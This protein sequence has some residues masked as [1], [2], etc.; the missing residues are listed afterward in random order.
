MSKP[1]AK[2]GKIAEYAAIASA[3]VVIGL[4]AARIT[5]VFADPGPPPLLVAEPSPT[6]VV[7][8]QAGQ[9]I[10]ASFTIRNASDA[11]VQIIGAPSTC[12]C[13]A[14]ETDF[15]LTLAAGESTVIQIEMTVGKY[16]DTG[17]FA[18]RTTLLVDRAGAVPVLTTRAVLPS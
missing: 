12:G 7:E 9:T 14:V 1:A 17:R 2:A 5:G 10:R 3:V 13:T 8:A 16:N 4:L 18:S 11:P 6:A 15:P